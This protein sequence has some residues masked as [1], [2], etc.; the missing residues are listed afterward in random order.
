MTLQKKMYSVEQQLSPVPHPSI[1]QI[2]YSLQDCK[3]KKCIHIYIMRS[4]EYSKLPSSQLYLWKTCK[5]KLS[6]DTEDFL[7][8]FLKHLLQ[9]GTHSAK[10]IVLIERA[11]VAEN[12][13]KVRDEL[14]YRLIRASFQLL[15][16]SVQP[17]R[18]S[19][20]LL[21]SGHRLL[22]ILN[23]HLLGVLPVHT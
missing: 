2:A 15:L 17:H 7:E 16:Y 13:L 4:N 22:W 21:I 12:D 1:F 10:L 3:I 8:L 5:R 23:K 20:E 9:P 14:S 19:Y 6:L 11:A 18:L